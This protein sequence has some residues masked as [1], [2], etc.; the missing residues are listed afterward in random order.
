MSLVGGAL[1]L[2]VGFWM[3]IRWRLGAC[4]H[5]GHGHHTHHTPGG[6]AR[7][8]GAGSLGQLALIGIGGGLVP[9]PAGVA[10]L[11][12]SVAAGSLTSGLG[13]A[14]A[15]SLGAG[16]VVILLSVVLQR[17]SSFTARWLSEDNPV[18]E[19]LPLV[20]SLMV[21]LVGMWLAASAFLDV[22]SAG[23]Y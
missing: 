4:A 17:A 1:V 3:L 16:S 8:N 22:M 10:M 13:L 6:R 9:C 15:F 11:M 21:I 19:H 7:Q 20:S 5:P 23:K 12:T 2:G 14:V 18:V